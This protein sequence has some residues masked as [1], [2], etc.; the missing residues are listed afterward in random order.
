[1][2]TRTRERERLIFSGESLFVRRLVTR[3]SRSHTLIPDHYAT[4]YSQDQES[5]LHCCKCTVQYRCETARHATPRHVTSRHD[6]TLRFSKAK[7]KMQ[8]PAADV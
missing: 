3:F 6:T 2:A 8:R 5:A 7:L 4:Q 1:M